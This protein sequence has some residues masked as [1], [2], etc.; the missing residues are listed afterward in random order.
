MPGSNKKA[1]IIL[2]FLVQMSCTKKE[3]P[4]FTQFGPDMTGINFVNEVHDSDSLNIL[5]YLYFYNGGGVAIGDINNDGLPDIYFSSNQGSNKLYLN[6]GNLKFEDIT[7]KA[8]VQGT[9]NW[10]TGVTMADVNGDGLLDIY[11]CTVGKFRN[12][13]GRN[14]LFINNG[15]LTFTEKAA[16]Y[17]LDFE[18]F[19]TQTTFFDYD[20]DG[21]LDMFLVNHSV[22]STDSYGYASKRNI[23]NEV[24]GDKLLRNDSVP[25]GRRFTEV[26]AEAGIYSS[27]IGYGLNVIVGD[28]NN[29]GWPDIY[30]SN[31]FHEDDYYYLNNQ[32][33]TFTERNRQAFGHT[34]RFSMGSDIGDVNNDGWLDIVTLDMLPAGH[35]VLKS[36]VSDDPLDIYQYKLNFGY[37]HQYS[38][39]SLQLNVGAGEKFSDIALFAG[40]AA[41]D[42]SWSPLLADFNNDGI[43]DLFISDGIVRRPNDLD[44]VNYTANETRRQ[45]LQNN[46][47]ADKEAIAQMPPGKVHNYMF[48]G[49]D[50]LKF[51]DRSVAWGFEAPTLS[52]GAAYADL[53]NDGD[54]DLV[55]NNINAPAGI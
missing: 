13:Y 32:D 38:R 14:Q 27:I 54:L 16:E 37:H 52:N 4:L 15:D 43:K 23:P 30:V 42:W 50:S 17:G 18:G 55:V 9:G 47:S 39:N 36:S 44:Y 48:Q 22:H 10:N 5:D 2:C 40:V 31:D 19:N 33:G 6:K 25:G 29:D 1:V 41:T 46:R 8:G 45:A 21:D 49:T 24:S 34:S 11:L 53:D 7:E 20:K 35:E 28:F 51:I 26:T 3:E 12:L